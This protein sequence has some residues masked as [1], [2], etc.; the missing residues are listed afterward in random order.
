[1]KNMT[2]GT[3]VVKV[4][5]FLKNNMGRWIT[6]Y[7]ITNIA[8]QYGERIIDELIAYG[9]VKST[10]DGIIFVD[11]S[12]EALKRYVRIFGINVD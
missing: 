9:V 7:E 2:Y 10:K 11:E 12:I 4:I 8:P 1:M 3:S 6:D 5:E